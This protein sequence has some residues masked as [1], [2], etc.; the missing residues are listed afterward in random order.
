MKKIIYIFIVVLIILLVQSCEYKAQETA[1][2]TQAEYKTTEIIIQSTTKITTSTTQK[3]I[4]SK[5]EFIQEYIKKMTLEEKIGQLFMLAIREDSNGNPILNTNEYVIDIIDK[6]KPGGFILFGENIDT[7]EQTQNLINDLQINSNSPLF[8]GIDEEGGIV[9]RLQKSGKIGAT[10]LPTSRLIGSKGN[11][12]LAYQVGMII[13]RELSA[14]GFNMD[15]APV[16][17]VNTN[18]NNPVIG[19]RA[20]GSDANIVGDMVA[21]EV[22]GIQAQNVSSVI[23]HF[24]GH[25]DTQ[26]D[27][28]TGAVYLDTDLESLKQIEF[29]PFEKGISAGADGVMVS[30]ISLA[31]VTGNNIPASMSKEIVTDILRQQLNYNGLVTTDALDM[32][33]ITQEYESGEVAYMSIN[34][35]VDLLVMPQDIESAYNTL[36]DAVK[37]NKISEKRINES[38]TRILSLK[39]DR[40]LFSPIE[41]NTS[42]IDI[43]GCKEHL[44]IINKIKE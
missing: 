43:L 16:A 41:I 33:A 9:S 11:T 23:K 26:A 35:G 18:P 40:N 29:I 8:I 30:H 22:E 4:N 27:T 32:G 31:N 34:A 1:T 3:T 42:A 44:D 28:H 37:V 10:K 19:N 25:G 5:E 20:F 14:L 39:Y 24:P 36:Y 13:G 17:D 21:T 12:M 7:V 6:Y 2:S 15:F 38:L